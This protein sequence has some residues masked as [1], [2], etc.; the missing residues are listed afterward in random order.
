MTEGLAGRAARLP[1]RLWSRTA[2]AARRGSAMPV[3]LAAAAV[4]TTVLAV[5]LGFQVHEQRTEDERRQD[6][7]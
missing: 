6:I 7:L 5:W 1:H 3:S 2:E 4:V